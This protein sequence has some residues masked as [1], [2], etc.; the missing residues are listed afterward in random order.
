M[1]VKSLDEQH[2]EA[3]LGYRTETGFFRGDVAQECCDCGIATM[4]FHMG[5]L[6]Y[7]CS[8]RCYRKFKQDAPSGRHRS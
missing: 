5:L 2:P 3:E 8:E 7:F 4:W 1:R 6:L